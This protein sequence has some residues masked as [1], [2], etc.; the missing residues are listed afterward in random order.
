MAANSVLEIN[1]VSKN[2]GPKQAVKEVSLKLN[3]GEITGL[4]GHNGA[5]KSTLMGIVTGLILKYQGDVMVN[6]E[7]IKNR[8]THDKIGSMIENPAFFNN[9]SGMDNL[10]YCA[11]MNK[12]KFDYSKISKYAEM[13]E[14][15]DV[16]KKKVKTYSIGMKKKLDF[17]QA[18]YG[19]PDII[20]LDEPTSGVD[21]YIIPEMR[22]IL[23][24]LADK[25]CG[26]IVASHQLSEIEKTCDK[27]YMIN[28]GVLIDEMNMSDLPEGTD[29]EKIFIERGLMRVLT[30]V[31]NE[32]KTD[33]K[34]KGLLWMLLISFAFGFIW[35]FRTP[36]EFDMY[37]LQG[38]YFRGFF[39]VS[40]FMSGYLLSKQI[41]KGNIKYQLASSSDRL[42]IWNAKML[43]V[44]CYAVMFWL[45]SCVYGIILAVKGP[46]EFNFFEIFSLQRLAIYILTDVILVTFAYLLSLFI[47]NKFI[48]EIVMLFVWGLPYQILP[49]YVY[50]DGFKESFRRSIEEKLTF[51]PQYNI[52]SWISDHGFT[53]TSALT[54]LAFALIFNTIATIKFKKL[55]V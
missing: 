2:Y 34:D 44:V 29:L 6:G 51:V 8:K 7:N 46:V 41:E 13:L 25:G 5:G 37:S 19:D 22:K 53:V 45:L 16:L 1:K 48:I 38:E 10:K 28:R 33:F 20:L 50:Y 18:I 3:K 52:V 35:I 55:E 26:I 32:I 54:V 31:K 49:F 43:A 17:M 12:Q 30:L 15:D 23:K 39:F 11:C 36:A 42:T 21:P 9:M 4:I 14:M 27:V 24:E 40:L 47:K